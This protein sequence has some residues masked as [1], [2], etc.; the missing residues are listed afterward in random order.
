MLHMPI[1][2][3]IQD[4]E[5]RYLWWR[6]FSVRPQHISAMRHASAASATE[7]AV[8]KPIL[9]RNPHMNP[10]SKAQPSA[11]AAAHGRRSLACR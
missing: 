6:C 3:Y 10:R 4:H 5:S 1:G 9:N 7:T 8:H 2:I 11:A